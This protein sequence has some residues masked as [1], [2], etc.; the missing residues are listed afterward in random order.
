M[1]FG[2]YWGLD[3]F[4]QNIITDYPLPFDD[5]VGWYSEG[6]RRSPFLR[7]FRCVQLA[8]SY[9]HADG[10]IGNIAVGKAGRG[11]K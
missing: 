4:A 9:T 3:Q 5:G 8:E 6:L 2:Q 7:V 1:N 10:I 11:E